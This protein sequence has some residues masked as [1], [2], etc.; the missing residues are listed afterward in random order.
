MQ[1]NSTPNLR[2]VMGENETKIYCQAT[3]R[4]T[5]VLAVPLTIKLGLTKVGNQA[6]PPKYTDIYIYIYIYI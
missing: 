2:E 5:L 1:K 6:K 4:R 3:A